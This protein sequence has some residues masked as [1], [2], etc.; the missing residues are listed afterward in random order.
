MDDDMLKK[1]REIDDI[2]EFIDFISP[3]Y[4]NIKVK[5]YTI[6]EIEK[7]LYNTFIKLIGKLIFYSPKNMRRFLRDYLLQFE[8]MNIKQIILGS[9]IGLNKKAISEKVNFL[10]EKLLGNVEFV[11]NLL[12]ISSLDEIQLFMKGTKYYKVIREGLLYFKNYNEVFVL[13]AFL[14]QLYYINM[15]REE[16]T[17]SRKERKIINLYIDSITEIYNLNVIYRGILNKIDKKLLSQFLVENYLFLDKSK[18]E[19]LLNQENF[20]EFI[21]NIK[22][23]FSNVKGI[24]KFYD[25]RGINIEHLYWW[26]EGLYI[27]YFFNKFKPKFDDIDYSTILKVIEILIKKQKE[28]QFDILPNAIKIIHKKFEILEESG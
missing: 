23:I 4:P 7:S 3:Y 10:T 17:F 18:I 14:D 2:K 5:N 16:K 1:L 28:I 9:I 22:E 19:N 26:I 24:K 11:N 20:N 13:E 12:E 15:I 21:S 8:I 6:E 27:N 25:I